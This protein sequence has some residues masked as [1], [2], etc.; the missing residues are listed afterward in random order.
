MINIIPIIS[1]SI[2]IFIVIIKIITM[3]TLTLT[4]ISITI[5]IDSHS[6]INVS[7]DQVEFWLVTS[8]HEHG[9]LCDFLKNNVLSVQVGSYI[10]IRFLKNNH[11]K[12]PSKSATQQDLIKI[13]LTMAKG[14]A[15]LH[16]GFLHLY[17][18]LNS[19]MSQVSLERARAR[20]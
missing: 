9:S 15:H 12:H 1:T 3:I 16:G 18:Y 8:F 2:S 4:I 20:A 19:N 6:K 5:I 7:H 14:L 13:C 11:C 10:R 17:F